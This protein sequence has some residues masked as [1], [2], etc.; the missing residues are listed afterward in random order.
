MILPDDEEGGEGD[1]G[2]DEFTS[3]TAGINYYV[4]PE[5]HAAKFTAGF[6]YLLDEP[7]GDLVPV[8]NTNLPLLSSSEDGQFSIVGQFQLVF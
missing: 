7:N 5:S 4:V 1:G 3:I 6:I 2:D 8:G